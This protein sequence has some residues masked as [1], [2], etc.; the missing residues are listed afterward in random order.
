M[1]KLIFFLAIVLFISCKKYQVEIENHPQRTIVSGTISNYNPDKKDLRL[2]LA[3]VVL[4]AKMLK[5]NIDEEGH[6]KASFEIYLPTNVE[7]IHKDRMSFLLHPG[8]S[9]HIAMEGGSREIKSVRLSGS[10]VKVNEAIIEFQKLYESEEKYSDYRAAKNAAEKLEADEFLDFI[11]DNYTYEEVKVTWRKE[12]N[13]DEEAMLWVENFLKQEQLYYAYLYKNWHKRALGND[14]IWEL[15][16]DYFLSALGNVKTLT[17][18]DFLGGS[19]SSR[20]TNMA[21]IGLMG[22]LAEL[23]ENASLKEELKS[24]NLSPAI[25]SIIINGAIATFKDD[26]LL[27]L[28]LA[29][30]F[31]FS[32]GVQSLSAYDSNKSVRE[33]YLTEDFLRVPLEKKYRKTKDAIIHPEKVTEELI[34]GIDNISLKTKLDS[35][36]SNNKNKVVHIDC[37]TTSCGPCKAQ[38]KRCKPMKKAYEGKDVAF[39]YLCLHSN[40]E[41]WEYNLEEL[42][43]KGEHI[44]L[45]KGESRDFMLAFDFRGVPY[46]IFL[47]R[48]GCIRYRGNILLDEVIQKKIEELL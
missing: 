35:L 7:L 26:M 10:A 46:H 34:S 33:R 18:E 25:D 37:W 8:D 14:T 9:L 40:K 1:K 23:P 22:Q 16:P 32:L 36:I 2:Y 43:V 45:N 42:D 19:L 24:Y 5:T 48:E 44:L 39:V 28:V 17:N 38:M 6:F 15:P 47:D 13:P 20:I 4:G 30:Y 11:Y 29:N 3:D 27:K 21:T 41:A 31:R 12:T